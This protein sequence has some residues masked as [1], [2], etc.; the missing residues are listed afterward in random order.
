MSGKQDKKRSSRRMLLMAAVAVLILLVPVIVWAVLSGALKPPQGSIDQPNMTQA[1]TTG[2]STQIAGDVDI[3]D[4]EIKES[5]HL[6]LGSLYTSS[7]L[8]PDG[9]NVYAEDVA[10]IEVVNTSDK[11]LLRAELTAAMSDGS[12]ITFVLEELPGGGVA[13]VFDPSNR[14]LAADAVCQ[15]IACVTEEYSDEA[16]IPEGLLVESLGA[17][18]RIT[19]TGETRLTN[20]KVVYRCDMGEQYFGG[21]AYE[22]TIE[23]LDPGASY[24]IVDDSLFG[25]VSVVR[26]Y[27]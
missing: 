5:E 24:Q 22:I 18:C 14:A 4:G 12:T 11:Y 2:S 9:G 25:A 6:V 7:I 15:Y 8:N 26:I 10:S 27:Q 19:N 1:D 20:L 16:P 3:G 21:I 23:A 13:E 17:G